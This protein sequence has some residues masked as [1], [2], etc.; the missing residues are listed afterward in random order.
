MLRGVKG[1]IG[2]LLAAVV[3]VTVAVQVLQVSIAYA[4]SGRVI[5]D[6]AGGVDNGLSV[7]VQADGR[8][9]VAGDSRDD[10]ALVRY[11]TNGTL[12]TSFGTGGRVTTDIVGHRAFVVT[13]LV[14]PDG[15]VLAAGNRWRVDSTGERALGGFVLARYNANGSLDTGFGV[16]GLVITDFSATA[17]AT[18]S[19]AAIQADGR[20]VVSGSFGGDFALARY[21]T[22]GT[23][24][25]GF[26]TGGKVTTDFFG[27]F[28]T[29]GAVAV[30]PD[31]RIIV[32]GA[33]VQLVSGSSPEHFGLIRYNANGSLDNTFG[34]AGRVL[35]NVNNSNDWVEDLAIQSDGR[36]VAAGT[37][38]N[39]VGTPGGFSDVAVVRY[40]LNGSLD[41]GFGV[42]GKVR[43]D[44]GAD[45]DAAF[46]VAVGSGGRVLVAGFAVTSAGEH[47]GL[48]RYNANGSL[49][50]GFGAGGKVTTAFG[51]NRVDDAFDVAIQS[52]GGILAAGTTSE[53]FDINF[54]LARYQTNGSLDT[55]FGM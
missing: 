6:F 21:N 36:I 16:G 3:A 12:D 47:F 11:N 18:A 43:T 28:D 38:T 44:F 19:D 39:V 34:T 1:R 20:I 8:I 22:D 31:G 10:F 45:Q 49:D 30:A 50:T 23:L 13:V 41:T 53:N 52:D 33:A 35:T 37:V 55:L 32:A 27:R 25:S 24:D 26:G 46:A 54:A 42:G 14:Q 40:N 48:V 17:R 29:S 51:S 7:A 5:T 4:A 9:I 15:R 2:R